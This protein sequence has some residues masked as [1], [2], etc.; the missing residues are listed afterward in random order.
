MGKV[1]AIMWVWYCQGVQ[2]GWAV[3]NVLGWI[4]SAQTRPLKN[5]G[6]PI[7]GLRLLSSIRVGI[8]ATKFKSWWFFLYTEFHSLLIMT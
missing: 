6:Y 2:A 8:I 1:L 7:F 4:F 5:W 3:T